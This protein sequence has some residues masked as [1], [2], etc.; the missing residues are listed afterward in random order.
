MAYGLAGHVRVGDEDGSVIYNADQDIQTAIEKA[1]L[2][3]PPIFQEYWGLL[4]KSLVD[5]IVSSNSGGRLSSILLHEHAEPEFLGL[6]LSGYFERR[7]HIAVLNVKHSETYGFEVG[8]DFF[9]HPQ[10]GKR[11]YPMGPTKPDDPWA[12]LVY[13]MGNKSW[14]RSYRK[15]GFEKIR[16]GDDLTLVEAEEVAVNYI[17]ACVDPRSPLSEK[18]RKHIGGCIWLAKITPDGRFGLKRLPS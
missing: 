14:L 9:V 4:T 11:A 12:F 1:G 2:A 7:P 8:V 6:L 10:P 17:R 5:G 3:N 13:G 18:E 15:P 16:V